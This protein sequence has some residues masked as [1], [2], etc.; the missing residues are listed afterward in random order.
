M[1]RYLGRVKTFINSVFEDLKIIISGK[2]AVNE[3][4]YP[5]LHR[6]SGFFHTY[7]GYDI[8][9]R[10]L[11]RIIEG[12][13]IGLFNI[14]NM[15]LG[16][17][18]DLINHT[19]SAV[20]KDWKNVWKIGTSLIR[21]EFFQKIYNVIYEVLEQNH[22]EL[23]WVLKTH[24]CNYVS[25]QQFTSE[26]SHGYIIKKF[27]N[28]DVLKMLDDLENDGNERPGTTQHSHPRPPGRSLDGSPNRAQRVSV[29]PE[30][31]QLPPNI[32]IK[33]FFGAEIIK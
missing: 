27:L 11:F 21:I 13:V 31:A 17:L 25:D 3:Y 30:R 5:S 4:E 6:F 12:M 32:E 26:A 1:E 33:N 28:A 19:T 15:G 10:S 23:R 29:S 16:P 2:F 22:E 9:G 7:T 20:T 24:L 18:E 14:Q 8:R